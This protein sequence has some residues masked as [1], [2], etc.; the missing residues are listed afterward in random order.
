MPLKSGNR[1]SDKG[2]VQQ[3]LQNRCLILRDSP[4]RTAR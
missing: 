2:M 4:S 3:M 1:F